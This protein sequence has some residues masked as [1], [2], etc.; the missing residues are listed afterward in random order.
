[1]LHPRPPQS[2]DCEFDVSLGTFEA[3]G[4][5]YDGLLELEKS[6]MPGLLPHR[7][8]T[9]GD[10]PALEGNVNVKGKLAKRW[11]LGADGTS[12]TFHIRQGVMSNWGNELT[13][14]DVK[15]T[16]DRKFGL[17]AL[18]AFYTSVMG[19]KG[20]EQCTVDSKYSLT[21]QL[22][23]PNPLLLKLQP[24]LNNPIY[25]STKCK[26]MP[27]SATRVALLQSGAVDIAQYLQP[28][29]LISLGRA[30]N[31]EIETVP[32]SFMIWIELNANIPPFDNVDVRRAMNYAF[33]QQQVLSTVYQDL[34]TPLNGC[35]PNIY[36]GFT[37]DVQQYGQ[38]LDKARELLANAGFADGFETS[39]SYN[40]GDP[41]QEPIAI[42]YQTALA[43]I[44]VQPAIEEGAGG[45][46]L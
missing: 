17:A 19:M 32:A 13:A 21:F 23:D 6:R 38:N 31:V 7:V 45:D 15:W 26:E 10:P 18:G 42:L 8:R 25:D 44:G 12:V 9:I 27:T 29:E 16:W 20:P 39:L 11:E 4:A 24:N 35:M 3:I 14:E 41:V 30:D 37:D 40:A 33:P 36:P 1:M 28:L 34:A 22:D 5:L 46:V 43:E 2:L